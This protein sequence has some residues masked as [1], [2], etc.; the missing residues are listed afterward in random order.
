MKAVTRCLIRLHRDAFTLIELLVVIAIIAI[1]ASLL[2]P[3]LSS[4]KLKAQQIKCTSNVKQ[5]TLSCL[6][7]AT[8]TSKFPPYYPA[9]PTLLNTVWMGT[10]LAYHAKV[11]QVRICPVATD[12]KPAVG[13]Y[14]NPGTADIAWQWNSPLLARAGMRGSY[15][16]NGWFYS[17]VRPEYGT[18]GVSIQFINESAVD[19]PSQTPMFLDSIWVDLW[20]RATDTPAR[21]LY[22]GYFIGGGQGSGGMS[23]VTISRHSSKSPATAPQNVPPGTPLPASVVMGLVDGHVEVARLEKLWTYFWHKDYIPPATRPN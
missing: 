18:T 20:P 8:D 3:A 11:D 15:A 13:G 22:T 14:A 17:D 23:R 21:N 4:A 5:L 1:L 12:S 7:Y 9:D 6:L 19:K 2:L 10:L 16:M